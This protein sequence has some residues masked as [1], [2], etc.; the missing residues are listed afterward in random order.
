MR[1]ASLSTETQAETV[2][3]WQDSVQSLFSEIAVWANSEPGWRVESYVV[4]RSEEALDSYSIAGLL[5]S[6]PAGQL[7]LE[8]VARLVF[9]GRGTVE[10]RALPTLFRVR[11]IRSAKSDEWVIL[12]DSGVPLRQEWN[13]DNFV[14]L[15]Q[16]LLGVE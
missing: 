12:T 8:P 2:L 4:E 11:I 14:R 16:D 3:E 7:R 15:A 9:G 6:T 10:L 13:R 1:N 5:I